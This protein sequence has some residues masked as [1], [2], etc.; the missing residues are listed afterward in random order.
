MS[1][2]V[3]EV[4]EYN[5]DWVNDFVCE[6]AIIAKVLGA[7]AIKIEHIGSTSVVGLSAK[8]VIDILIE[9]TSVEELDSKN[10]A[11]KSI[12]FLAKG[13]NTIAARRY[14]QKAGQQRTHH[15]HAFK[16]GDVNLM[17]HRAFRD[18]L[19]INPVVAA[20]YGRI[21][22]AAAF[23]HSHNPIHYM[24][25]KSAFIETH[26]ALAIKCYKSS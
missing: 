7:I 14:F 13:E 25:E 19:L 8:P 16:S 11:M 5:P 12:G 17:R 15:I 26:E 21:K 24:A 3:I 1:H 6:K 9:V 2:R 10:S 4:V 18:Y 22:I 23:K 20:Q